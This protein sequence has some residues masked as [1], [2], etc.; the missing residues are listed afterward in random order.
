M[1][2]SRADQ[3]F[4]IIYISG[5]L[6]RINDGVLS[7]GCENAIGKALVMRCGLYVGLNSYAV[8]DLL[9]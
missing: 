1:G 4:I 3:Q 8:C 6:N 9:F 2:D 7:T 5:Q